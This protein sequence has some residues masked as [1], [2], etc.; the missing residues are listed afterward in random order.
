GD[1]GIH[2]V[3]HGF[4]R[5][6]RIRRDV[7]KGSAHAQRR[8]KAQVVSAVVFEE[9]LEVDAADLGVAVFLQFEQ[10]AVHKGRRLGADK[11]LSSVGHDG[12]RHDHHGNDALL[13]GFSVCADGFVEQRTGNLVE[14]F[15]ERI[16]SVALIALIRIFVFRKADEEVVGK[17]AEDKRVQVIGSQAREVF[18]R[19][20]IDGFALNFLKYQLA[21]VCSAYESPG[22]A[23]DQDRILHELAARQTVCRLQSR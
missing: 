17:Q 8:E 20:R 15:L 1:A 6:G 10:V 9:A 23:G 11:K 12:G 19:I 7:R 16:T 22:G 5:Q 13:F 18:A 4:C 21:K 14:L 2:N 3:D